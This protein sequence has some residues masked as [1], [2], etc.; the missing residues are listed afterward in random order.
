MSASSSTISLHLVI[1]PLM[2]T[3]TPVFKDKRKNFNIT[4]IPLLKLI[5]PYS[6]TINVYFIIECGIRE[7]SRHGS[8]SQRSFD[9]IWNGEILMIFHELSI[10]EIACANVKFTL[11][12]FSDDLLQ[13][14]QRRTAIKE[15]SFVE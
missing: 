7:E 2:S 10:S 12:C 11:R 1:A 3:R 6:T 15:T 9:E 14:I 5:S 4:K 8:R 13:E